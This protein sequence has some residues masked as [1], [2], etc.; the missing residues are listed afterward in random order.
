MLALQEDSPSPL[1]AQQGI[2]LTAPNP[3]VGCVLVRDGEE[4]ARGWHQKAGT[5]HAE[6]NA[7][8]KLESGQAKDATAYVTLEPCSSQGTTGACT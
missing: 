8:S 1:E 2:G 5:H 7:L 3:A 6:R 4:L